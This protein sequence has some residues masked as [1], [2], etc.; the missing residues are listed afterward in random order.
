MPPPPNPATPFK[1]LGSA[2]AL[3]FREEVNFA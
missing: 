1:E 2:E 3:N